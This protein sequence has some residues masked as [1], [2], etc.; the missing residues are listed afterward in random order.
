MTLPDNKNQRIILGTMTFGPDESAGARVTDLEE[1]KRALDVFAKYG[2]NEL[3]TARVYVGG[4]ASIFDSFISPPADGL[5]SQQ[6][7]WTAQAGYKERG[8]KIASK[9]YP[10][11]PGAVSY[12]VIRYHHMRS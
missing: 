1:Y 2:H 8:F 4:K 10:N 7:D 5:F 3:D 12:E 9:W 6:E 11:D